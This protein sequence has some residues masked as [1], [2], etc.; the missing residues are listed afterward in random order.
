M[1]A[2]DKEGQIQL[3]EDVELKSEPKILP[4]VGS[5]VRMDGRPYFTDWAVEVSDELNC[6][7]TQGWKR[8]NVTLIQCSDFAGKDRVR[9]GNKDFSKLV[10]CSLQWK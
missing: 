4:P 7:V 6:S 2:L 8:R 1:I 10:F 5:S 9:E 3:F